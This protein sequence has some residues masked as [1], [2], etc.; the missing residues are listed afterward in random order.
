M[1]PLQLSLLVLAACARPPGGEA[2]A[3]PDESP[4]LEPCLSVSPDPVDLGSVARGASATATLTVANDCGDAAAAALTVTGVSAT[5]GL[6]T[7]LDPGTVTLTDGDTLDVLVTLDA[8]E[9]GAVADTIVVSTA[10]AG[11]SLVG[12]VGTVVGPAL[13]VDTTLDLG[14]ATLGC[15]V[16]GELVLANV[17]DEALAV[18]LTV[19]EPTV[20]IDAGEVTIEPGAPV[21]VG[22]T[23]APEALGALSTAVHV[24]SDDPLSPEVDVWLAGM[25]TDDAWHEET[26]PVE[27]APTDILLTSDQSMAGGE[28]GVSRKRVAGLS[29]PALLEALAPYDYRIAGASSTDGCIV[30][31]ALYSTSATPAEEA[32]DLLMEQADPEFEV[33]GYH[34]WPEM[35]FTLYANALGLRGP[36]DCNEGLL[37]EGAHLVTIAITD[38]DEQS[39]GTD[40]DAIALVTDWVPEGQVRIHGIAGPYPDACEGVEAHER[41]YLAAAATGGTVMSVCDGIEAGLLALVPESF[42]FEPRLSLGEEADPESVTV[43]IDGTVTTEWSLDG[44]VLTIGG[45]PTLGSTI[46]ARYRSVGACDE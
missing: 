18:T 38:E 46:T 29:F 21:S 25:A 28:G 14:V 10:E 16:T 32:R 8:V 9:P 2:P 34:E 42:W 31:D 19:D 37:R 26:F 15:P 3:V 7:V 22:L 35:P 5:D 39:E 44:D 33:A 23:W 11:S 1:R 20:G 41:F 27:L 40:D 36:G 24:T 45:D 6:V 12:V 17:G 30:G 4:T 43:T 13:A